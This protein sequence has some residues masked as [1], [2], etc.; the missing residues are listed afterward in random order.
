MTSTS[1]LKDRILNKLNDAGNAT[2]S[3][4]VIYE[5]IDS[6]IRDYTIHLP[7]VLDGFKNPGGTAFTQFSLG[8]EMQAI[9]SVWHNYN[10]LTELRYLDRVPRD[11]PRFINGEGYYYDILIRH[12]MAEASQCYLSFEVPAGVDQ[13][14]KFQ[15]QGWHDFYS[16]NPKEL[17]IPWIHEGIIEQY[18]IW[19]A[20]LERTATES[21]NPDSSTLLLAQH[22]TNAD[23]AERAYR[24]M[25]ADA[26][27]MRQAT[28]PAPAKWTM[29]KYDR[30]Y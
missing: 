4:A 23:K 16:G 14:I 2:W 7:R 6:G 29:D 26:K 21:Q 10:G 11:D 13:N 1:T 3:D 5:W 9:I 28:N 19:Q 17:T 27:Q 30:S 15:Y 12:D 25:I 24:R 20:F 22:A 18:V 8:E